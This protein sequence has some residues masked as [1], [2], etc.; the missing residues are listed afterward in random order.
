MTTT[1]DY[2]E[3]SPTG[4]SSSALRAWKL[5]IVVELDSASGHA[6]APA[7]VLDRKRYDAIFI[8]LGERHAITGT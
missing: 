1:S 6:L 3:G 5:D 8:V 7:E 2:R 4:L